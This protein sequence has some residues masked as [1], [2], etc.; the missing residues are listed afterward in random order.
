[1]T[2]FATGKQ[3]EDEVKKIIENVIADRIGVKVLQRSSLPGASAYWTP[4]IILAAE[5]L[6]Y[7]GQYSLYLAII[8]CKNIGEGVHPATYWTHM[9]RAYMELNNLQLNRDLGALKARVPKIRLRV[10]F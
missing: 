3:L 2:N 7:P 5:L 10:H 8:E 4:D 6:L 9:S 1:M